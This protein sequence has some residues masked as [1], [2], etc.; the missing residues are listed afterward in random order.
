MSWRDREPFDYQRWYY[1]LDQHRKRWAR[2]VEN[3][4]PKL[5][6]QDCKGMGG[7]VDR[8]LDDGTGPWMQCGWCEGV[9]YVTPHRRGEWLRYRR[10]ESSRQRRSA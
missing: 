6:C 3:Q 7:E 5:V 9:G 2:R 4:R 1:S 10:Q 8:I